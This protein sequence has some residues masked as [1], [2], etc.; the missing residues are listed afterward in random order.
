MAAQQRV[1]DASTACA[2]HD[3]AV[4]VARDA[5][6]EAKAARGDAARAVERAKFGTRRD[7]RQRLAHADHQLRLAQAAHDAVRETAAPFWNERLVSREEER[8]AERAWYDHQ[9]IDRHSD[10]RLETGRAERLLDAL[11]TWHDWAT[12]APVTTDRLR[13]T[14]R[15]LHA[16]D[17]RDWL[18]E[19]PTSVL[20]DT[21]QAWA[22][23]R[24]I[25]LETPARRP[26]PSQVDP[27]HPARI[28][29][30]PAV[31][32]DLGIEL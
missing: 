16:V 20:A 13:Q 2:S 12:G 19:Q 27:F 11:D 25:E 28:S 15:D 4:Q 9:A 22:T 6:E 10:P 3:A 26:E 21:L 17:D 31:E 29:R 18:R 14:H 1:R 32:H 24:G 23:E 5:F 7:A 8:Q 30:S